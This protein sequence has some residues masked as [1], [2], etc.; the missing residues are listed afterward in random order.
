VIDLGEYFY[1][2]HLVAL[3]PPLSSLSSSRSLSLFLLLSMVDNE[4][5]L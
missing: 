5:E 3:W 2:D 1:G 4:D